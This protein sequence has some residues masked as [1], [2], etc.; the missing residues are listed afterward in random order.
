MHGVGVR[1]GEQLRQRSRGHEDGVNDI[2]TNVTAMKGVSCYK[3]CEVN[4]NVEFRKL[5]KL[6]PCETLDHTTITR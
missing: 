1:S 5:N 4:L 6:M 2:L 3:C